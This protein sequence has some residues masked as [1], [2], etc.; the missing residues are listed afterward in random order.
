MEGS[1]YVG[2]CVQ[3]LIGRIDNITESFGFIADVVRLNPLRRTLT[4]A[5]SLGLFLEAVSLLA[6]ILSSHLCPPLLHLLSP[7]QIVAVVLKV[8]LVRFEGGHVD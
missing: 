5:H 8:G 4:L 6:K 1:S 3:C 7:T 2:G